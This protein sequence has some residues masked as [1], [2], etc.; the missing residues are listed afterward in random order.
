MSEHISKTKQSIGE[1][2]SVF[3]QKTREVFTSKS[4][5]PKDSAELTGYKS[6]SHRVKN[7]YSQL[8]DASKNWIDSLSRLKIRGDLLTQSFGAFNEHHIHRGGA[9]LLEASKIFKDLHKVINDTLAEEKLNTERLRYE[10]AKHTMN[11]KG[12]ASPNTVMRANASYYNDSIDNYSGLIKEINKKTESEMYKNFKV[13]IEELHKYYRDG[14]QVFS[15]DVNIRVLPI[16]NQL[17]GRSSPH[18]KHV[19]RFDGG[20]RVDL[21]KSGGDSTNLHNSNRSIPEYRHEVPVT[22]TVT[23]TTTNYPAAPG[24]EGVTTGSQPPLQTTET[25]YEKVTKYGVDPK[26]VAYVERETQKQ[27][28]TSQ[29]DPVA[30]G[31]SS[32]T[33]SASDIASDLSSLNVSQEPPSTTTTYVP[34]AST[35]T[36]TYEPLES[37]TAATNAPPIFQQQPPTYEPVAASVPPIFQQPQQPP[38]YEPVAAAA[39]PIFQQQQQPPTYEPVAAPAPTKDTIGTL[40]TG[41]TPHFQ[42]ESI[43]AIPP[44]ADNKPEEPTYSNPSVS[45]ANEIPDPKYQ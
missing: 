41:P 29:L 40:N 22:T 2:F 8:Y 14:N 20:D 36:T 25:T 24:V 33:P 7:N 9:S 15:G 4:Q 1:D 5:L 16:E 43:Q 31:G 6:E 37:T 44:Q 13:L 34:A 3:R 26:E 11:A 18:I 42:E 35:T 30:I 28:Q 21:E 19:S 39:P 38:T 32:A 17:P 10:D 45:L 27:V 12:T 23:T